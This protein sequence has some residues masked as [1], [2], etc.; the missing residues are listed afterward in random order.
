MY[1][2]IAVL[3]Y[4]RIACILFFFSGEAAGVKGQ[5]L[6]ASS[7][8]RFH[9]PRWT[10]QHDDLS[11][12]ECG[13]W[14]CPFFLVLSYAWYPSLRVVPLHVWDWPHCGEFTF[15]WLSLRD[16]EQPHISAVRH[17]S[18]LMTAVKNR[19]MCHADFFL[20]PPSSTLYDSC[21]LALFIRLSVTWASYHFSYAN[22]G[23]TVMFQVLVIL[24]D[25]F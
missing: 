17:F 2:H 13:L 19:G 9:A 8:W 21:F 16:E 14:P 1:S 4:L 3:T 5:P 23:N 6:D 22:L 15:F 11:C 25:S 20:T 24:P 12:L 10:C 7:P 18:V